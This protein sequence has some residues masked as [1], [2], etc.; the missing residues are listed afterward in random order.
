MCSPLTFLCVKQ[1]PYLKAHLMFHSVA[2]AAWTHGQNVAAWTS[3][4]MLSTEL[5]VVNLLWIT[6]VCGGGMQLHAPPLRM[7]GFL[8]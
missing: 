1:Q 6:P 8:L 5:L 2:V 7:L 3:T 4:R